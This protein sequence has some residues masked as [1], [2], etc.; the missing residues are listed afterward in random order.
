MAGT[1][2]TVDV[3]DAG[4]VFRGGLIMP[5]LGLMK[6]SL[7]DHTAALKLTRGDYREQPRN[8][9]DAM[10]SGCISAQIGAIER[11]HRQFAPDACCVISGGGAATLVPHL[12]VP[13]VV[14]Q[15]LVLEG[16]VA[17]ADEAGHSS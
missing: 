12:R 14:V 8:T 7:A 15:N 17:L 1:A 9:A 6:R 3:L 2:T 11:M 10:E 13:T 4:G 16:V 5:G